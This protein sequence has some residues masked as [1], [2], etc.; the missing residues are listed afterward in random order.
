VVMLDGR[1]EDPLEPTGANIRREIRNLVKGA[2]PRDRF[3]FLFSG[4]SVQV[5]NKKRTEDDD[6]DECVI[7]SDN[8]TLVDD[9]LKQ[10]LVDPLPVGCSL[11]AIFDTCHSATLLDLKHHR[12]N[13]VYVPWVSKELSNRLSGQ[14]LPSI[15]SVL[16]GEGPLTTDI[17]T[18]EKP[19]SI[20]IN[21]QPLRMSPIQETEQVEPEQEP[22]PSSIGHSGQPLSS[23]DTMLSAE[24]P[25]S[26]HTSAD[27]KPTWIAQSL[28]TSPVQETK[29]LDSDQ[30][31]G[32]SS[33]LLSPVKRSTS[34]RPQLQCDGFKLCESPEKDRAY[35]I[36]LGACK[37]AQVAWED[38]GDSLTVILVDI[39]RKDPHPRLREMMIVINHR[40]YTT[41]CRLHEIWKEWQIEYNKQGKHRSTEDEDTQT[42]RMIERENPLKVFQ[43]PQLASHTR[44]N[45]NSFFTL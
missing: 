16:S 29:Q 24:Q 32:S 7:S 42:Y 13:R 12:C 43:D 22:G 31:F 4:H 33:F 37:D 8:V 18:A 20:S 9:Q 11:V 41:V 40:T 19:T 10:Y 28:Q 15:D 34:P 44:L 38:N 3:L 5:V 45:M 27:E 36:A 2:Q 39:L 1:M 26:V 17:S 25:L 21:T 35:V 14:Q 23:N 30:E 6:K